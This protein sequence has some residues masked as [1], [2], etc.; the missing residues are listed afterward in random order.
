[1]KRLAQN[2]YN[3]NS[4]D[5]SKLNSQFNSQYRLP[6][7][8]KIYPTNWCGDTQAEE[9]HRDAVDKIVNW[10]KDPVD[11]KKVRV[12]KLIIRLFCVKF[13][14]LNNFKFDHLMVGLLT[15]IITFNADF[16]NLVDRTRVEQFQMNYFRLLQRYL[17]WEI[18]QTI[19]YFTNS[20]N[21]FR[22]KLKPRNANTKFLEAMLLISQTRE[23][24]EISFS[25]N[26]K[27]CFD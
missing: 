23:A 5:L 25:F 9:R 19:L 18:W 3:L 2:P 10:S 14:D 26:T 27:N 20:Y 11:K 21:G 13:I 8:D 12:L 24:W 6:S 7:Y 22:S 16:Y 17:R 15:L 1:M 4:L